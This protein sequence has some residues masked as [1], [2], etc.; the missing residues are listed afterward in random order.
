[1][2]VSDDLGVKQILE[3][4]L[5]ALEEELRHTMRAIRSS[6]A[7][8]EHRFEDGIAVSAEEDIGFAV[9]EM[10]ARTAE[11]IRRA[12]ARLQTAEYGLC[13]DC[14]EP[15]DAARLRV[16]PFASRCKACQEAFEQAQSR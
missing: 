11:R 10:K 13:D 12:L 5:H 4:R 8:D 14:R 15:I 16:L 6:S 1:M 3:E 9:V 2:T 7:V